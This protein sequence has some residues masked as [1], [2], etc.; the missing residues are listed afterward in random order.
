MSRSGA[1]EPSRDAR[2][3]R[4]LPRQ[5]RSQATVNAI[6][7]AAEQVFAQRGFASTTSEQIARRAGVGVGSLY[8][9]FPNKA[10]IA[11]A[12]LENRSGALADEARKMFMACA[13]ESLEASLPKVI[14][15][16]YQS[17]RDNQDVFISLV[18]EVPELRSAAEIYSIDRLIHRSSLIYLRNYEDEVTADA[19]GAL[20][21]FLTVVF[22]GSIRQFLSGVTSQVSEQEFLDHLVEMVLRH[23][24]SF[25]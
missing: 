25:R 21:E 17:Y 7:Q 15:S 16:L 4:R 19:I 6:L 1:D 5:H 2:A 23:I 12:L 13:S 22:I 3:R 18:N 11:L 14:R 9:Y 24:R 10:S 20:H 8:D